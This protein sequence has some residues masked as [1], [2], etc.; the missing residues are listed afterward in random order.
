MDGC[1][2]FNYRI[3]SDGSSTDFGSCDLLQG[4]TSG[5]AGFAQTE[6]DPAYVSG[7]AVCKFASV[8]DVAGVR[9]S[10]GAVDSAEPLLAEFS[11]PA[12]LGTWQDRLFIAD[13]ANHLIRQ[14]DMATGA[15]TTVA[16]T[17]SRGFTTGDDSAGS[18]LSRTLDTPRAVEVNQLGQV[19]FTDAINNRCHG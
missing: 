11:E 12:G 13:S 4:T 7:P 6:A 5:A 14:M 8:R 9:D 10:A 1:E 18:A 15:V 17:G 3:W 16:G 19:Y 2:H